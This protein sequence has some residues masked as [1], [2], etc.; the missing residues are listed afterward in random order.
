[1]SIIS[2]TVGKLTIGQ[3]RKDGYVNATSMCKASGKRLNDYF[4]L[5]ST[6][7]FLAEL[8]AVTGYPV[9]DL[10]QVRQGGKPQ[11]Q[12]TWVHPQ[13]AVN[14]AQWCSP[15]FAVLVSQW[16]TDW[17]TTET[18]RKAARSPWQ[19]V[20]EDGKET[21][22]KFTDVVK[23]YVLRHPELMEDSVKWMYCNA[24]DA[25]NLV[26]FG[27]T[28]KQLCLDLGVTDPR[29]LRN[30]L[31]SEELQLLREMENVSARLCDSQD[32]YPWH[33]VK[34]A[35]RRLLIPVSTRKLLS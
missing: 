20:R 22:R 26:V 34:E 23:D 3:R 17:I 2:R 32:M 28:A 7:A 35:Q 15:K 11:D 10:M 12:G 25:I 21:R 4:R 18:T 30:N 13:V 14:L 19:T 31:T 6:E 9:T 1:M 29:E 33:A 5:D 27:R 8:S 24:S 16:V